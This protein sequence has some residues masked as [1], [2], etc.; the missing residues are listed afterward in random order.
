MMTRIRSLL[1]QKSWT[2]VLLAVLTF[3][4]SAG[5]L[6]VLVYRQREVLFTHEWHF[7]WGPALASFGLFGLDL[8]VVALIWASMMNAMGGRASLRKHIR[9]YS[10]SHLTRRLPGT[11]WYVASRTYWYKKEGVRARL[12]SVASGVELVVANLSGIVVSLVFILPVIA[13]YRIGYWGLIGAFAGGVV[14]LHPRVMR[15]MARRMRLEM[16][17]LHYR[18]IALWMAAYILAWMLGGAVLYTF[19][20]ALT[21]VPVAQLPF[22]IGSWSLAGIIS[23]LVFFLPS[24][25]GI[26]EVGLSLLLSQIMPSPIAV[27][28][29]VLARISFL[30]YE[31]V[32]TAV[33]VR[34]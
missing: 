3:G 12:T 25:M 2:Q 15:W 11:V 30:L 13:R 34:L 22:L 6:G 10:L 20:N 28:V 5:I 29:V 24:N 19:A 8:A 23:V 17:A 27:V 7:R 32:W 14:L 1:A 21:V 16:P 33:F 31:I 18:Q 26:S 9:Y 4:L